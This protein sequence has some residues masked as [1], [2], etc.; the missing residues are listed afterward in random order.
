MHDLLLELDRLEELVEMMDE[1]G[2]TSRSEAEAR[3]GELHRRVDE[4]EAAEEVDGRTGA[5]DA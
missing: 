3:L 4:L 1:L 5:V 2:V